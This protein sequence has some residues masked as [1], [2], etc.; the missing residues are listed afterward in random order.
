MYTALCARNIN[1]IKTRTVNKM[2]IEKGD[3]TGIAEEEKNSDRYVGAMRSL[4][5]GPEL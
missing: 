2:M 5:C 3:E 1:L 4:I